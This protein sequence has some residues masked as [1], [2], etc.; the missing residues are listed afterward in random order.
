MVRGVMRLRRQ[1]CA[2]LEL[3][4]AVEVQTRKFGFEVEVEVGAK[5]LPVCKLRNIQHTTVSP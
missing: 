5:V 4:V 2:T 1:C 3:H